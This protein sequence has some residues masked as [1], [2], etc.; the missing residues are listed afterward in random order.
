MMWEGYSKKLVH[1]IDH[2]AY[3]GFFVP[4]DTHG[5]GVRLVVSREGALAD[6]N[7]L[8]LY[9]L[10]NETNGVIV[11]VR[12]Q[13]FGPTSLIGALEA[14]CQLLMRKNY[15]QAR[16]ITADLIDREV[17]DHPD[18][19]AF[20][21]SSWPHLNL[22]LA[23]IES[24]AEHCSDIPFD[25]VYVVSPL[26]SESSSEALYP[27]WENLDKSARKAVIEEVIQK[28]IRPYIELD[29]G[30]IQIVDLSDAH[31]LFIAYEGSCT[32]CYSATGSTLNAIQQI[33]QT[34]VHPAIRVVPDLSLLS[35]S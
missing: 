18:R 19:E 4:E 2:P 1:K 35:K 34:R 14:A 29:A 13:V 10:V 22:V 15:D 17:R 23:A 21:R 26:H 27:G 9:F 7:A 6:A 20:P 16:R 31:E 25:D 30:G 8:A 24:F 28:E 12:F 33:L 3:C 32:S 11:D 5:R